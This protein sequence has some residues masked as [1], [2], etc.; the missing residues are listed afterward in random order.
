MYLHRRFVLKKL[1]AILIAALMVSLFSGCERNTSY[2]PLEGVET[3]TVQDDTGREVTV[4][5][6]ITKV[7]PSGS[8]A[9]LILLTL[10]PDLLVGLSV[11]PSTAQMTYYPEEVVYLPTFGQFYGKKSTLNMESLIKAEPQITI[12]LGDRKRTIKV[13]LAGIQSKTNI[14][15]VFY[16]STIEKL[17]DAYRSLGTLLGREEKA[18]ELAAFVEKTLKMAEDHAKKIPKDK[19][20]TV[21][22][23][24]GATG[25]A[26]NAR[27]SAHAQ[28][29]EL[30]GAENAIIPGVVTDKGGGT[31]V[32]LEDVYQA[33]PDVIIQ[34]NHD[35]IHTMDQ[36]EWAQLKAVREGRYYWIPQEPYSWMSAPPSVNMV[37]GVWW[38]GQLVYPE[39][40]ND[41]D[42]ADI[43]KEYYRLF[44]NYELSDDEVQAF[45][46]DSTAKVKQLQDK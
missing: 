43:A 6:T 13:D 17:P 18:E 16:E 9:Q 21:L 14:P 42:M 38:L 37:L 10:V 5:E 34:A 26:V 3:K 20:K 32:N 4:P 15:T 7:A 29:I 24:T 46:Q 8:V 19:R 25:L 27:G 31:I 36:G 44:W 39:I 2:D 40:Y 30:I 1:S 33:E 45:L 12:D 41:Y 35:L 11:S 22:F 28:V 23:G